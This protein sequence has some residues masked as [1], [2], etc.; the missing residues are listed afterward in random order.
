[1]LNVKDVVANMTINGVVMQLTVEQ[2]AEKKQAKA[3]SRRSI[4][5]ASQTVGGG[6]DM[7]MDCHSSSD[8]SALTEEVESLKVVVDLRNDEIFQLKQSNAELKKQVCLWL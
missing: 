6:S 3:E 7:E 1:V 5:S 2:Q 8:M 4:M